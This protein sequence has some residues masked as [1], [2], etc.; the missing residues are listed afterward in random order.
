MKH[1][2]TILAVLLLTPLVALPAALAAQLQAVRRAQ[3]PE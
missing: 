1:T 3:S 2:L